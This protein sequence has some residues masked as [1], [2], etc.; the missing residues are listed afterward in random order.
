MV[1]SLRVLRVARAAARPISRS[2]ATSVTGFGKE[3]DGF[4]G[5]VGHTPLVGPHPRPQA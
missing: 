2:Y 5:A 1:T 4:V 3:V